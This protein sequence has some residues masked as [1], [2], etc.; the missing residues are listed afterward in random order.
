MALGFISVVGKALD[1][2][3]LSEIRCIVNFIFLSSEIVG[4]GSLVNFLFAIW[5]AEQ[6]L[7]VFHNFIE[8]CFTIIILLVDVGDQ[9]LLLIILNILS[10]KSPLFIILIK[11]L[12]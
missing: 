7:D 3:N 10:S 8:A 5:S 2:W 1:Q 9:S 11:V 4:F 12:S 6:I